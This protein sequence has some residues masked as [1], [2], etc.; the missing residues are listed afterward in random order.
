[1][2]HTDRPLFGALLLGIGYFLM[3]WGF[4]EP[5]LPR[6]AAVEVWIILGLAGAGCVAYLAGRLLA[7]A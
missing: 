3:R 4:R 7:E 2:S 6:S 5:H 1:M